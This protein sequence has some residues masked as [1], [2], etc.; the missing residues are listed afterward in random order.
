MF[1]NATAFN[2]DIGSWN[3]SSVTNISR[4]FYNATAFNQDIDSWNV[5]SVTNMQNMFRSATAFNQDIDSWNVSSVTTMYRMFYNATAFNQ[6]I[7]SWN[8]SSV[9]TME[10]MFYDATAFNQDIGSWNVSSVTTM[11]QMFYD[12]TA[13]NQNISGWDVSSVV[14]MSYMFRSATAFNQDI[15]SWNVSSVTNISRMFYNATAF[16]QDIGS[17]NVSSVTTMKNMFYNATAFNQNI[18]SWDVSSVTNMQNM[19]YQ[20]TSFDQDIGDWDVSN[21]T[22]MTSMFYAVTL[23]TAN[24]DALLIGWDA[25][26]LQDNVT[27]SGGN[28]QYSSAAA[29]TARASIIS[30]DSWTI[31]DGGTETTNPTLSSSIPADNATGV[32]VD[33]N[34]VLTFSEAVDVESGNITIKKTSDDSTIATID[35]TSGLVTGT[36]TNTITV[37][38]S[39]D[40]LDSTEYYV[41]IDATAFDDPSGNSYAGITSTTALSFSVVETTNPTMTITASEVSD[42]DTSTDSTLVL[43]FTSNEVTTDFTV[44]DI[45]VTNATLSNFVAVSS[46]VY[47]ATLTPIALGAVTIDVAT[48]TFTDAAGNPNTAATQFNWTYTLVSPLTKTNVTDNIEAWS[49]VAKQWSRNSVDSISNRMDWLRRHQG[50]YRLSHQGINF[51]FEN[52]LL[53][54]IFNAE[55]DNYTEAEITEKYYQA[56]NNSNG[57]YEQLVDNLSQE[58]K[59]LLKN[60]ALKLIPMPSLG[61]NGKPVFDDWSVWSSGDIY[62][63]D[64][65]ATAASSKLRDNSQSITIGIDKPTNDDGGVVGFALA[66]GMNDVNAGSAKG[67]VKSKNYSLSAYGA[68]SSKRFALIEGVIGIGHLDFETKRID[69][70]DTYTGELDA[71]QLFASVLLRTHDIKYYNLTISSYGKYELSRTRFNA[72]I[73]SGGAAALSYDKH[74]SSVVNLSFGTDLHYLI[75]LEDGAFIPFGKFEFGTLAEPASTVSMNYVSES[76]TYDYT[77]SSNPN[78]KW[79]VVL[80]A[81]L[82]K[83]DNWISRVSYEIGRNQQGADKYKLLSA[84]T[85]LSF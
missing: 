39:S 11:E 34:I 47:T 15:G 85:E 40:L 6:D 5:S 36:G 45:T 1:Y 65:D 51:T 60:E 71:N 20:A 18:G 30:T 76:T 44:S 49:N 10:Q 19:F 16:N 75:P 80:G 35:V 61:I 22:D 79:R 2:Q 9:T 74:Y 69:G 46:T 57:S 70:S 81:D 23:S 37:N 77:L 58:F 3:V 41:L 66:I 33:S 59:S 28:S 14:N 21:V 63:G 12:A 43:T 13:F 52:E 29:I 55:Y 25:L 82:H 32:A 26:E 4:M 7:G 53:N 31:T 27:F 62:I 38:P 84:T 83:K 17:W 67:A 64:V 42:G 68:E 72:F 50:E 54:T 48:S 73:E 56:F 8:V 24:Y 78:E